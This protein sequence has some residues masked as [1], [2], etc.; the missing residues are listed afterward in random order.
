[1]FWDPESVAWF[2]TRLGDGSYLRFLRNLACVS[3]V[4]GLAIAYFLDR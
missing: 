4:A 2:E 3:F 1:M